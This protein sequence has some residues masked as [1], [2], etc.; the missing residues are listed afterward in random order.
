MNEEHTEKLP[1]FEDIIGLYCD[2]EPATEKPDHIPDI[3]K[4]VEP[5]EKPS[6][7]DSRRNWQKEAMREKSNHKYWKTRFEAA[8]AEN[9]RLKDLLD[10]ILSEVTVSVTLKYEIKQA[11]KGTHE[12]NDQTGTNRMA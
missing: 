9:A 1:Q 4:K 8:N 10:T 7:K 6:E 5:A 3:R 11:L 12:E 2:D